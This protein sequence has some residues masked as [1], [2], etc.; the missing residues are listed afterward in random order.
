MERIKNIIINS[1][2]SWMPDPH[3]YLLIIDEVESH[4]VDQPDICIEACKSLI[5]GVSKTI[6]RNLKYSSRDALEVNLKAKP[7]SKVV[8]EAL[9]AIRQDNT[10]LE[11]DF[12]KRCVSVVVM[13]GELRN[14]RGD[15]SHGK[16]AP[17]P[18][19]STSSFAQLVM[20]MSASILVFMLHSYAER[21]NLMTEPNLMAEPYARS[22]F[23]N[24]LLDET[25]KP[26]KDKPY[27]RALYDADYHAYI[28]RRDECYE[29][30]SGIS[31]VLADVT[32]TD[33]VITLT[34]QNQMRYYRDD[35]K[36]YKI[37]NN[38]TEGHGERLRKAQSLIRKTI[39][40]NVRSG[41][42][43]FEWFA[44]VCEYVDINGGYTEPL[45]KEDY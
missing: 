9:E 26:T 23:F 42:S 1:N 6:L 24:Q 3:Y 29:N 19:N 44:E 14:K 4:L 10:T 43:P 38:Q 11:D 16:L 28:A 18:D 37:R 45:D 34:I 12:V 15:I 41:S 32:E 21:M 13:M 39:T 27:S 31:G 5:E 25:Y 36:T 8:G 35:G 40:T 30:L 22:D 17:K 20:E 2:K 7:L 33:G